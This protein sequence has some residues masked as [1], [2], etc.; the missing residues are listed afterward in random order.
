[1]IK[2][3]R[4]NPHKYSHTLADI[5]VLEYQDIL[6]VYEDPDEITEMFIKSFEVLR[7]YAN[8]LR[9]G[10]TE[11][12][13]EWQAEYLYDYGQITK[14]F[15]KLNEIQKRLEARNQGCGLR[16][17][18]PQNTFL[19]YQIYPYKKTYPSSFLDFYRFE[20]KVNKYILE[21]EAFENIDFDNP[22]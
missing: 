2:T 14:I 7:R 17:I 8:R 22:S 11:I 18:S 1:M 4:L 6:N 16:K 21:Q 20:K 15:E 5:L 9:Q 12:E 19:F 10:F 13:K 3:M